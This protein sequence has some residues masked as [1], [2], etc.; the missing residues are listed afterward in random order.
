MSGALECVIR[1]LYVCVLFGANFLH[2]HFPLFHCSLS[3]LHCVWSLLVIAHHSYG[4]LCY[5]VTIRATLYLYCG[6]A[7]MFLALGVGSVLGWVFFC[8]TVSE[9]VG[10]EALLWLVGF[11]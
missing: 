6:V 9:G 3:A 5:V 10:A 1:W 4:T 2:Y 8:V 11:Q 7:V